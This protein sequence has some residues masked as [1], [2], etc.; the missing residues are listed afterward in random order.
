[1]AQEPAV[2]NVLGVALLCRDHKALLS[3]EQRT[4]REGLRVRGYE[5]EVQGVRFP[6]RAPA[7]PAA[8]RHRL[9]HAVAV[10]LDVDTALLSRWFSERI[11]GA[12]VGPLQV[13]RASLTFD[14]ALGPG[15]VGPAITLVGRT[16]GAPWTWVRLGIEAENDGP[17]L[18]LRPSVSWW[19]G[20]SAPEPQA[21]WND[22]VRRLLGRETSSVDPV[23]ETLGR[24]LVRAGWKAPRT[25]R[26]TLHAA[27]LDAQHVRLSFAE[28]PSDTRPTVIGPSD[29]AFAEAIA[30]ACAE[31]RAA[32]ARRD[33]GVAVERAADMARALAF[34]PDAHAAAWQWTAHLGFRAALRD[35][36][37]QPLV[38]MGLEQWRSASPEDAAAQRM[39]FELLARRED[40]PGM[41]EDLQSRIEFSPHAQ[42]AHAALL[43]RR[44]GNREAARLELELALPRLAGDCAS[45]VAWLHALAY[46][47]E[48]ERARA[49]VRT[50]GRGDETDADRVAEVAT[51]LAREGHTRAALDTA[52][53]AL[54]HAPRHVGLLRVAQRAALEARDAPAAFDHARALLA[55]DPP[56]ADTPALRRVLAQ[57]AVELQHPDATDYLSAALEDDPLDVPLLEHLCR[58]Q[59]AQ[60]NFEAALWVYRTLREHLAPS[61]ELAAVRL[62]EAALLDDLG[63]DAADVWEILW[64]ALG[65]LRRDDQ[66]RGFALAVEVAPA[67]EVDAWVRRLRTR[68]D[69]E[70]AIRALH[71][72]WH[73]TKSPD[74]S[75]VA[76]FEGLSHAGA[77][78]EALQLAKEAAA[79]TDGRVRADW[80]TRAAA[81]TNGPAAAAL[82][83]E[84]LR[85]APDDEALADRLVGLLEQA[86]Q[87][88]DLT[89]LW[90]ARARDTTLAPAKRLGAIDRLLARALSD[91]QDPRRI[92]AD[93]PDIAQLFETRLELDP[94]DVTALLVAADTAHRDGDDARAAEHW[95]RALAQM[96]PKDPRAGAAGRAL[97]AYALAT[98]R[99]EDALDPLRRATAVDSESATGWA[100]LA[101]AATKTG[102]LELCVRARESQ[103]AQTPST[104][105]RGDLMMELSR[106]HRGR[107]D[108]DESVRWLERVSAHVVEDTTRHVELSEA[109]MEIARDGGATLEQQL[110]ARGRVRTL[111]GPNQPLS[112]HRAEAEL[113]A[114]AGRHEDAL[115]RLEDALRRAPTDELLLSSMRQIAIDC[116]A[117]HRYTAALEQA[118]E[119]LPEGSSR[120]SLLTERA[121]IALRSGNA[122]AALVSLDLL[123]DETAD[124]P[125]LLD[126]RDWAVHE[127]GREDE[128]LRRVGDR[129]RAA[130]DDAG[131]QERLRRLLGSD[132]AA[133]SEH[134]L[135]LAQGL[136]RE[137][138]TGLTLRALHLALQTADGAVLRRAVRRA[139]DV[140]P[141]DLRVREAWETAI[142]QAF[143][144]DDPDGLCDLLDIR[145]VQGSDE[146]LDAIDAALRRGLLAYPRMDRLHRVL[147][148][149]HAGGLP[150]RSDGPARARIDAMA[151][152]LLP[153]GS[154]AIE[155]YIGFA[156][157]LDRADA[158]ALLQAQARSHT[159]D[160]SALHLLADALAERGHLAEQ[161]EVLELAVEHA[162][163]DE[164]S[165]AA[166]KQL[167][168][169]AADGVGDQV[170]SLR[171]LERAA[172]MAPSDPDLLLP[173]LEHMFEQP[174]L[175]SILEYSD[176]VLNHVEMGD[177]GFVALAHRAADAALARGDHESALAF[178][179]RAHERDPDHG[180][181]R[182]RLDELRTLAE[183]PAHRASLLEQ[184]AQRQHGE[185]RLDALEE[186]ARL[187]A[188]PLQRRREAIR[189]FTAVL[190]EDP[191]RPATRAAL[192]ELLE[193]EGEWHELIELQERQVA[194]VYGLQRCHLLRSIAQLCRQHLRDLQRSE[195]AL[196][197]ALEHLGED[198]S[199]EAV[200]LAEDMRGELVRDL[201]GQGRYVDL[202]IYLERSLAP[203]IDGLP[204]Q[205]EIRASRVE[206][207]IELARIYRGPLDDS[208]KASRIY[209]RL[210]QYGRLPDEGLATLARAYQRAGRHEDLVRILKVRFEALADD[211]LRQAA[212]SVHIA[213]LLENPLGRPHE[214]AGYYLDAYLAAPT[215]H[216]E[217]GTK[218]HVLLSGTEAVTRVRA[219]LLDRLADLPVAHRPALLALLGDLLAV[220]DEFEE[221]AEAHYRSALEQEPD[222]AAS[223]EA[224]GRL[225]A[226]Q[227]RLDEA[228]P[229]LVAAA[230]HPEIEASRAAE[231]AAVAARVLLEL[232]RADEA[233]EVLKSALQRTPDSQRALLEL[234]RLYE[235]SGRG[236]EQAIVLENLS[237]LP[238]SS[239]LGAEVAY[240]RAILLMPGTTTDPY[241]AEAERARAYLLEAVSADAKHVA[242]RQALMVLARQRLEWSVVAHMHYLA[243]RELPEGPA[244]AAHHLDLAETYIE[245]LHDVD[246]A[247]RNIES[248]IS[249]APDDLVISTRAA[250]LTSRLPDPR[251][252]A[253]RLERIAAQPGDLDD[254][255]RARLWLL[256]ADLRMSDDDIVAAE[257]A[258]QRV[259]DLPHAS[260]DLTATAQRN[261]D[262]LDGD[263][264]HALRK[265]KSGL[266]RLLDVE[267][268]ATERVHILARLRE[269][270]VALG[271]R[272]LEA[273]AG[274]EQLE[275]AAGLHGNADDLHSAAAALRDAYAERGAY[276]EVVSLY[277][278]IAQR[279][280]GAARASALL[281]SAR[282]AWTA[283]RDPNRALD[284]LRRSVEVSPTDA[285][286]LALLAEL[287]SQG[288]DDASVVEIYETLCAVPEADRARSFDLQLSGI[289]AELGR[290]QDAAALLRP[291]CMQS[292]DPDLR[293]S[294]LTQLDAILAHSATPSDRVAI[295]RRLYEASL[296][297]RAPQLA[298]VSLELARCERSLGGS[299]RGI[300]VL[301]QA[302]ELD[303][304][305]RELL[306]LLAELAEE[307]EDWSTVGETRL[308]LAALSSDPLEQAEQYMSAAQ[309]F[310][311]LGAAQRSI[312]ARVLGRA[313]QALHK[314]SEAAPSLPGPS[315]RLLPLAFAESRWDEVLDLSVEIRDR[316]GPDEEVLLLAALT[317][318]Y[319]HGQRS[320]ARDLGFRHGPAAQERYLF[321]GLRQLLTHVATRGPLP[322]LDALLAAA[323]SL[324]GGRIALSRD[325][326]HW[327]SGRPLQAGLALGLA[328]LAEAGGQAERA[329]NLYQVTA[330]M[331]P[332][333][334]VPSLVARLPL[335]APPSDLSALTSGPFE[336]G[337]TL[338]RAL[339]SARGALAG[340]T[341]APDAEVSPSTAGAKARL[342]LAESIVDP[343]RRALGCDFPL[344]WSRARLP[345]GIGLANR[346][347]PTILLGSG[348]TVCSVAELRF[349]LARAATSIAS[350]LA[351]LEDGH[352]VP[353]G[354]VLDG[355]GRVASPSHVPS[356]RTA[357]QLAEALTARN[358]S[359]PPREGAQLAAELAHWRTSTGGIERLEVELRRA[360]LLFATRLCGQLD[361]ALLTLAH[362]NG[363]VGEGRPDPV[364]TLRYED[365]YWLLRA[366]QMY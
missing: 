184:V 124:R 350:G 349:R 314:A 186:R 160:S 50:A 275:L 257:A 74:A 192:A 115:V 311:E 168:H 27:E 223:S 34:D 4:L 247:V 15:V 211:P 80:L 266:L 47:D 2:G 52:A 72:R 216:R 289:A 300:T 254:A 7:S 284:A 167:A 75:T 39:Q 142:E 325:L 193:A 332:D 3:L 100:H 113:L 354:E 114:A 126:L 196:R 217:A 28:T 54:T 162:H 224:L 240:R 32:L 180:N 250:A 279:C 337:S 87:D 214:A 133:M 317:E 269:L 336:A 232:G 222:H 293:Y 242:A 328:R 329:R 6:M 53:E 202:A 123:S 323:G 146:D 203:E 48:P 103:L 172:E 342:A 366:L 343:W 315:V 308:Q 364:A 236:T 253:D 63:R 144:D 16:V 298:H 125:D 256:A 177:A 64:P 24:A 268:Q 360:V 62:E 181:T 292:D 69:L 79:R 106:L 81:R 313:R 304:T 249:Q 21:V 158:A 49:F 210:E 174:D 312:R 110:H 30:E 340:F 131:L 365:A 178:V 363:F 91:Q 305:H 326:A 90:R 60:G 201:E 301:E 173:L 267:K 67:D 296:R 95:S 321:P 41:L 248:A 309:A 29:P 66:R 218:A 229:A 234:A 99:P 18:T 316:S 1:M 36:D 276:A 355:L 295:T 37:L 96:E 334:P 165:V 307:S 198:T 5:A 191:Q 108:F 137:R 153:V 190:R 104:A 356:G 245:H 287:T 200:Q 83:D 73:R 235:R 182:G 346:D 262:A 33:V 226:R 59:R 151:E 208:A 362:D 241:S 23:F 25:A 161:L 205:H 286:A 188:G 246:S 44:V 330:F 12:R 206:L 76:L 285:D 10:E 82:L 347:T 291:L 261:L 277:E 156:S 97:G 101:E 212:V 281:E 65:T 244:R 166:L 92:A 128:E 270:G 86:G 122:T 274:H 119:A 132:E 273:W 11:T 338:R 58:L 319:R 204:D 361:G 159:D 127:L 57:L 290:P 297:R 121:T 102:D 220:H 68:V 70:S 280:T 265:Q 199:P 278:R 8:L 85:A 209:E 327:S 294:A 352:G 221:E 107:G 135:G 17:S 152:T 155:L 233:E 299:E 51:A 230:V 163:S 148:N 98:G 243:I 259:L 143:L 272:E 282:F 238:L 237:Q 252:I 13:E 109:W 189:E 197:V 31:V 9:S 351:I 94:T 341:G 117:Q 264:T 150:P 179:E 20:R 105:A 56:E 149:R 38:E 320:L 176:R 357:R 239:M 306:E 147:Q 42:L 171:Y 112:E 283:L 251:R 118:I 136:P 170:R 46:A 219:Q 215:A 14:A 78:A 303:P 45:E 271:D 139:H 344:A 225:L 348:V 19:F 324:L 185:A 358:A 141:R 130:P 129:I 345:G 138:A 40:T 26:L 302:L 258:T 255:A 88:T 318:A 331:V 260:D 228:V 111:L 169:V 120:D 43:L 195:Q 55:A 333:G 84:A 263:E 207:L 145:L 213:Q 71:R 157:Q 154:S 22:L 231:T 140:A 183:D 89:E 134:L 61:P 35:E 164:A 310:I 187:L 77:T 227:G 359:Q 353:L 335:A 93:D 288:T 175:A 194:H 322:R 339:A 116:D